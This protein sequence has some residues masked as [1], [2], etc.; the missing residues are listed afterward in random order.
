MKLLEPRK[1]GLDKL[2]LV[3]K[4]GLIRHSAA[5]FEAQRPDQ[6]AEK[7]THPGKDM[8]LR[9]LPSNT[10]ALAYFSKALRPSRTRTK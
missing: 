7:G 1:G 5:I 9:E 2:T 10:G 8:E 3:A 6:Y 4:T